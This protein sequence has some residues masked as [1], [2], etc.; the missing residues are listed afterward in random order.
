MFILAITFAVIIVVL[1]LHPQNMAERFVKMDFQLEIENIK[2]ISFE[3]RSDEASAVYLTKDEQRELIEY[4]N[5]LEVGT[6]NWRS[7]SDSAQMIQ[8]GFP[9]EFTVTFT[10]DSELDISVN[11]THVAFGSS[12]QFNLM[13]QY[14]TEPDYADVSFDYDAAANGDDER[15]FTASRGIERLYNRLM[16]ENFGTK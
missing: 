10:D 6:G 1:L 9:Q 5:K 8:G 3:S 12:G 4:I 13:Y 15:V 7:Y 2:S 14:K 16:E 11:Y